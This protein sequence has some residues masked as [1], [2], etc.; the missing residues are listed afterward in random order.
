MGLIELTEN[1]EGFVLE[2][3]V[4]GFVFKNKGDVLL[5]NLPGAIDGSAMRRFYLADESPVLYVQYQN[6]V[7]GNLM[8]VKLGEVSDSVK[9]GEWIKKV[10]KIYE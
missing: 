5:P 1:E 3:A 9:A 2:G 6:S 4:E 10:N 7:S 8:D